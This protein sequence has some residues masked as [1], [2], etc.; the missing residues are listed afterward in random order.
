[1]NEVKHGN[2]E[3]KFIADCMLGTLAKRLRFLGYDT[4]FF[5][6]I[7]DSHLVKIALDQNR[8]IITRDSGLVR[9]KAAS[10]H[11]FIE[12]DNLDLQ[13]EAVLSAAGIEANES[14][15]GT[16]CLLCNVELQPLAKRDAIGKVPPFIFLAHSKFN[17]CSNCGRIYWKGS[18]MK[19]AMETFENKTERK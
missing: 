2:S 8:I 9:R 12:S 18:H 16:R 15:P 14:K 13:T 3:P 5:N 19:N 6:K 4:L 10:K 11:I 7:E 1:M 17:Q